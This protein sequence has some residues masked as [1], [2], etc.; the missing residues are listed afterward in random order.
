MND[1]TENARRQMIETGVPKAAAA[2][3]DVKYNTQELQ[4][5]FEVIGF[6]APFVSV[7]R[8]SDGVEGT[9]MF[10]HS[11]RVYFDFKPED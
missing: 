3:A 9:M 4:E 7:R 5:H 2:L 6:L 8:K 1:P 11:P 10:D